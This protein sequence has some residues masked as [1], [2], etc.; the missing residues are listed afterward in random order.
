VLH[1]TLCRALE[2]WKCGSIPDNPA[3][4]L[5]RAAK[6]RAIDVIRRERFVVP[7]PAESAALL[8]SE[9]TLIPA[10][11]ANF[12][13]AAIRDQELSLMF[14]CCDP[15]ISR[16]AQITV[17]LKYL[18]GFGVAEIAHAFLTNEATIE[19]RLTR[20]RAALR[21]LG[22]FY[23]IETAEQV[24]SRLPNI[25]DALYLLFNEGYH[26]AHDDAV[27]RTEMCGEAIRLV[28]MLTEHSYAATPETFALLALMCFHGSR[29]PSRV[30]DD[31]TLITLA[32]QDRSLWNRELI[33]TG[34]EALA[35]SASG[36]RVAA[37]H[38]EAAIAAQ[39]CL[40]PSFESTNWIAIV[41]LYDALAAID[42]SPVV[43]LNRAIAIGMARTAEDGIAAI[44]S[45]ANRDRLADYPFYF[46]A[47][48]ELHERV[49]DPSRAADDFD[50]AA[51]RSRNAGERRFFAQRAAECRVR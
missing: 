50:H 37:R 51:A 19:K 12:R 30:T 24:Q 39:H 5:M 4:W 32:R 25:L 27:Q 43:A 34:L 7:L 31:G 42:R 49:G 23:S 1:D 18:G 36:D 17:I 20:A 16:D 15:S 47:L 10:I 48:G 13:D 3:A 35:S 40:A 2:T 44:E 8:R 29:I 38:I 22:A 46:A 26:S 11:E 28:K 41:E 33:A 45:I 14:S 21:K 9:W 6:N